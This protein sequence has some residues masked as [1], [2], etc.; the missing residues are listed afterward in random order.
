M[1]P[2]PT[3]TAPARPAVAGSPRAVVA[4]P[5]AARAAHNTHLSVTRLVVEGTAVTARIRFFRDDLEAGLNAG[6]GTRV[7]LRAEMLAERLVTQYVARTLTVT[8]DGVPV[9]LA[10]TSAGLE[11]DAPSKEEVAWYIL[12]GTVRAAPRQLSVLN[13]ALFD[14]FPDQQNIVSILR[15]PGDARATLYFIAGDR[16]AQVLTY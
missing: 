10:V 2:G 1:P 12:E 3:G 11:R 15:L 6:G 4:V 9:T 8:A 5:A 7:A 14:Q 13:A 16:K